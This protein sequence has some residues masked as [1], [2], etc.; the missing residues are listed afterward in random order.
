MELLMH[1]HHHHHYHN[2]PQ[3]F[4]YGGG[5]GGGGDRESSEFN[6]SS[7]AFFKNF[8]KNMEFDI[9][10]E[11]L[12]RNRYENQKLKQQRKSVEKISLNIYLDEFNDYELNERTAQ[13]VDAFEHFYLNESR[14][15]F[16]QQKKDQAFTPSNV[17]SSEIVRNKAH[18]D[19]VVVEDSLFK[20]VTV[21]VTLA[22]EIIFNATSK[23]NEISNGHR[24]DALYKKMTVN[25]KKEKIVKKSSQTPLVNNGAGVAASSAS[26]QPS[27]SNIIFYCQ[28][29]EEILS[30]YS[31]FETNSNVGSLPSIP[32]YTFNSSEDFDFN[33]Y[34]LST[35]KVCNFETNDNSN[36][37][38][39][40]NSNINN[41]NN[42]N[43]LKKKQRSKFNKN[44]QSVENGTN[45]QTESQLAVLYDDSM[46]MVS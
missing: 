39:N 17:N 35:L 43:N 32:F 10:F 42:K 20:S 29:D 19:S 28:A 9:F 44:L 3:F 31:S 46:V 24:E 4:T 6:N 18:V 1:H 25:K 11:K 7:E 30:A 27:Y 5:G 8:R 34:F 16:E 22:Q 23:L 41:Y 15:G 13:E 37:V 12:K 45:E 33:S 21:D 38:N 40:N 36:I 26:P 14:G 2:Q